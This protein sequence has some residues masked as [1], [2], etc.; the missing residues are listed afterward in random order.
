[1][2][3]LQSEVL[4]ETGMLRAERITVEGGT[5]TP[6]QRCPIAE[7]VLVVQQGRGYLYRSFGREENRTEVCDGDV[8]RIPRLA[9]HRLVA[10]GDDRIV[11][12]YVTAAP[13]AVEDRE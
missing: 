5:G 2:G 12:T 11:A 10:S 13:F 7:R 3:A 6:W 9:W 4:V 1:M 8:V